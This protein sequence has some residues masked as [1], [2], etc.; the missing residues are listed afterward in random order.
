M[1][2]LRS[3]NLCLFSFQIASALILANIPAFALTSACA[4]KTSTF[5]GEVDIGSGHHQDHQPQ[6]NATI[7]VYIIIVKRRY[8]YY[9]PC[10]RHTLFG[11]NF[12]RMCSGE[13]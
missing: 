4:I 13:N 10:S 2:Q 8:S 12:L 1:T 3:F 9:R 7:I 5:N 6:H 11:Q